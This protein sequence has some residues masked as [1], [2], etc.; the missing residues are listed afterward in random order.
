M[1]QPLRIL[2]MAVAQA[3]TTRLVLHVLQLH[4]QDMHLLTQVGATVL[5]ATTHRGLRVWHLQIARAMPSFR[6][7]VAAP[8]ATTLQ[9]RVV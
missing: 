9:A 5:V 6:A 2:G 1:H 7:A 4:R 3:V 8:V